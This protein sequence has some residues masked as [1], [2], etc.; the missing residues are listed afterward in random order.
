MF[1]H[2]Y[3]PHHYG[4]E[5]TPNISSKNVDSDASIV[6][7]SLD[8]GPAA[9]FTFEAIGPNLF[10]TTFSSS[11]HPL[12][13][14]PSVIKPTKD[15]KDISPIATSTNNQ[16]TIELGDI[17]AVVDWTDSPVISIFMDDE[18][19]PIH[20]DLNYRSYALDSRGVAHYTSYKR[21]TLHVGL[22]EK[23]APMNLSNRHFL[24][25]AT[26]CFG[27]D[28]YRTDPMYKHIPLLINVT[29]NGCAA[30]F[31]T[32][33]SRGTW[34]VGSEVD[35]LWGH[36]KVYRQAYG[37]LEEYLIVGRTL[38]D[39]L[40]TYA[41]LVGY[42]KLV[43]R[44][45]FGYV[46]GG[47]KYSMLD[48]PRACDAHLEFVEKLK[49]HDIPCSAFQMSSGYTVAETEPKTRNV[50]TWNSHRFPDPKGFAREMHAAGIRLISNVKP[51]VLANHPAYKQLADSGALFIDPRTK[52][53]AITRLWSAGGGE[54]GEGSHIDFTSLA[55]F[56]WWF[57]GCQA[58]KGVG[59][60][61][62]WNDNNEYT[63]PHDDWELALDNAAVQADL[64]Q[65]H[66]RNDIGLWGRSM[67]TEL[68][69]KASHDALVSIDPKTRPYVLTRSA[70]AGTM[71]YAAS[72]WSGDNVTSWEG[73]KGANAL[74]L[75]AGMSLL[76]VRLLQC[77]VDVLCLLRT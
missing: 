10:R 67:Q 45:A 44:W 15:L 36:Y 1:Q 18:Q 71:R 38:T 21:H 56:Q 63:I 68:M 64:S 11:D 12:P 6:L 47:M 62:I 58:L 57:K 73:M 61:G 29:S 40:K 70:T 59:I 16:K 42:P 74:S 35:G 76:T 5:E 60:D 50:F 48:R 20:R 49:Q 32:S 13:P 39:I 53:T 25:S 27:Y 22:G 55:G 33:H 54:S 51:Y 75:N 3:V 66:H 14:H 17:T 52:K 26:D 30:I 72:S 2:E 4:L 41:S 19:K 24:L 23:A 69:G 9:R 77:H 7:K 31:S 8:S 46:A 65:D 34:A 43:P 37:G 28:V